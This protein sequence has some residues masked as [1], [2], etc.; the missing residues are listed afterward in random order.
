MTSEAGSRL[1]LLVQGPMGSGKSRLGSEMGW[2]LATMKKKDGHKSLYLYLSLDE[3]FLSKIKKAGIP[4]NSPEK[5]LATAL[6]MI[7]NEAIPIPPGGFTMGQ[8]EESWRKE[9]PKLKYI[10]LHFDEMQLDIPVCENPET[11]K[12]SYFLSRVV[13]ACRR[14]Y[15]KSST[16]IFVYPILTG[17]S[18]IEDVEYEPKSSQAGIEAVL[19]DYMSEKDFFELVKK[20]LKQENEPMPYFDKLVRA[21]GNN[22]RAGEYLV[23]AVLDSQIGDSLKN[24]SNDECF[25]IGLHVV[26]GISRL[27]R[28]DR[29]HEVIRSGNRPYPRG[30]EVVS[31]HRSSFKN[32]TQPLLARIVLDV[33]LEKKVSLGTLVFSKDFTPPRNEILKGF[34]TRNLKPTR[35]SITY[36][37]CVKSGMVRIEN[38]IVTMPLF[39]LM[40]TNEVAKVFPDD[41]RKVFLRDFLEDCYT[42]ERC[43]VLSWYWEVKHLKL[44]KE[45]VVE[46]GPSTLRRVFTSVVKSGYE[47]LRGVEPKNVNLF[48][49]DRKWYNNENIDIEY[50]IPDEVKFFKINAKIDENTRFLMKGSQYG[51]TISSFEAGSFVM[52]KAGQYAV[53]GL[54]TL[55]GRVRKRSS[56]E[57][58]WGAW[59][60]ACICIAVQA[61]STE[62]ASKSLVPSGTSGADLILDKLQKF[63][64]KIADNPLFNNDENAKFVFV[65]DVCTNFQVAPNGNEFLSVDF[66]Y[67]VS[68]EEDLSNI[69]GILSGDRKRQRTAG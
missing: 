11:K 50:K 14:M 4:Y 35:I 43:A 34:A 59:E 44:M 18:T 36:D 33:I 13:A 32:I 53:D 49:G 39:S 37:S 17:V 45:L 6:A 7:A 66:P 46:Q 30:G 21:C 15:K 8:I 68:Y 20:E 22:P 19:I 47:W 40:V 26:E 2:S 54:V 16:K 28:M 51:K 60:N 9:N 29:W 55:E 1:A 57:K 5:F 25:A 62:D 65:G 23:Q 41:D 67:T 3:I 27:Y 52:N 38:G 58:R 24:A 31:I 69:L 12:P 63:K 56:P 64:H 10:F 42:Y 61:K 48:S